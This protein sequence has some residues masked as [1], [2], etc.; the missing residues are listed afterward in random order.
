M[1][2]LPASTAWIAPVPMPSWGPIPKTH[3]TTGT[4]PGPIV[5]REYIEGVKDALEYIALDKEDQGY[6]LQAIV[7]L[8]ALRT[9]GIEI[10]GEEE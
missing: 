7:G 6:N 2:D 4:N 9:M 3:T 1:K 8:K 5:S 10:P